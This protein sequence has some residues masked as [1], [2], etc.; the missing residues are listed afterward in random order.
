MC[1][2]VQNPTKCQNPE[3]GSLRGYI[4]RNALLCAMHGLVAT[5]F[6]FSRRWRRIWRRLL[7]RVV[8]HLQDVGASAL[9][10]RLASVPSTVM[11]QLKQRRSMYWFLSLAVMHQLQ[12]S[13]S[14]DLQFSTPG[15]LNI[16]WC[17][18]RQVMS[19]WMH[20]LSSLALAVRFLGHVTPQ[21]YLLSRRHTLRNNRY[22]SMLYVLSA[23]DQGTK[24][25]TVLMFAYNLYH[26]ATSFSRSLG[27]S[28]PAVAKPSNTA[29]VA[30][31]NQLV[32]IDDR[33]FHLSMLR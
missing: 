7:N 15:V 25:W 27:T 22:S 6:V 17:V 33:W 19:D 24:L 8:G 21:R 13:S 14:Q 3:D 28:P 18:A 5:T 32:W 31:K 16:W 20:T 11:R 9:Y 4:T 2:R 29:I 23:I 1:V 10:Q 12:R 30:A 26:E